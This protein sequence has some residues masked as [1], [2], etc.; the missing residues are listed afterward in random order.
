MRL[1]DARTRLTLVPWSVC[2]LHWLVAYTGP[3]DVALMMPF[4]ENCC[5]STESDWFWFCISIESVSHQ[6]K[7]IA[8]NVNVFTGKIRSLLMSHVWEDEMEGVDLPTICPYPTMESVRVGTQHMP[9][10]VCFEVIWIM[11]L[12]ACFLVLSSSPFYF[13]QCDHHSL[14]KIFLIW[15]L[16][17]GDS[18]ADVTTDMWRRT[19]PIFKVFRRAH[20]RS[21]SRQ[22]DTQCL[23][24]IASKAR[25]SEFGGFHSTFR[26]QGQV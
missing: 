6:N 4:Y 16:V 18:G 23:S 19:S 8:L 10:Q 9:Y 15:I 12:P 21:T 2:P 3:P 17:W 11:F 1:G 5:V 25:G 7:L 26:F 22:A 20:R 13:C 24:A 14:Y